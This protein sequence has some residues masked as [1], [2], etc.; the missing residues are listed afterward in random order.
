MNPLKNIRG[1]KLQHTAH[2]ILD[3]INDEELDASTKNDLLSLSE[4]I[5]TFCESFTFNVLTRLTKVPA[6]C[7]TVAL[8]QNSDNC[9]M[10]VRLISNDRFNTTPDVLAADVSRLTTILRGLCEIK[11]ELTTLFQ[12]TKTEREQ[13]RACNS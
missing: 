6:C 10:Y 3:I 12:E 2:R 4:H 5:V 9:Y 7:V 1:M 8:E 11:N 13:T